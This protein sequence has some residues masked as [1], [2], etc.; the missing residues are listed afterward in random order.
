MQTHVGTSVEDACSYLENNHVIAIPTETVYGLAA[1]AMSPDAIAKI[2]EIKN[3]PRFNPLIL[4]IGHS[5]ELE[6]YITDIPK[7]MIPLVERYM[8]GPM[9]L[10][11]PKREIVSDWVTSGSSKVA[12]RIPNHALTLKL[13]QSLTFPL[14]APSANISGY[15]SPTSAYHVYKNL[16]GKI[17]YILDGGEC[18]VGLESTIVGYSESNNQIVI[19]RLGGL[20]ISEIEDVIH[21]KVQLDISHAQPDTPGQLRSHYATHTPLYAGNVD[22][23]ISI[24]LDKKIITIRFQNQPHDSRIY[25]EYIMSFRGDLI[26][27]AHNLFS[28]LRQADEIGGDVILCEWAPNKGLGLAINDRIQ[29]AQAILKI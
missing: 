3:R 18:T 26:E 11:L 2:Y 17:P 5:R 1:N 16:K 21:E 15:V 25:R 29:R 28:I 23:L 8:P 13:L 9:T 27:A 22:E 7:M 6:H 19:H 24:F 14:V 4:H 12:I 10:L 20:S